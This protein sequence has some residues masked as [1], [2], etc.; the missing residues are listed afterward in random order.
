L[1]PTILV[2]GYKM[3]WR[4]TDGVLS[5]NGIGC[6]W[7][8]KNRDFRPIYL[9]NDKDNGHSYSGI[10]IGSYTRPTQRCNFE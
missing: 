1:Y 6:R 3:L 9:G 8:M 2:F 10:L 4:N 7:G 5:N